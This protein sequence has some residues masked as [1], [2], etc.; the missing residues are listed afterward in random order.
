MPFWIIRAMEENN[1]IW[2]L[3]WVQSRRGG[4]YIFEVSD[5]QTN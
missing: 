2:S 4:H 3:V 5:E 1:S